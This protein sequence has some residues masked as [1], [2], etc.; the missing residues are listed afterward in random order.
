MCNVILALQGWRQTDLW[1][2]GQHSPLGKSQA[3]ERPHLKEERKVGAW[4][5]AHWLRLSFTLLQRTHIWFQHPYHTVHT[6][7]NSS[8][9]GSV[10][11][12]GLCEHPRTYSIYLH[13][14]RHIHVKRKMVSAWGIS[15]ADVGLSHACTHM[16][17][18][19]TLSATVS[20]LPNPLLWKYETSTQKEGRLSLVLVWEPMVVGLITLSLYADR[21]SWLGEHEDSRSSLGGQEAKREGEGPSP[22]ICSKSLLLVNSPPQMGSIT[23][24]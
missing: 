24:P 7:R 4:E 11:Y 18:D 15:E 23:S 6:H 10:P 21:T 2:T 5:R 12:Y 8:C 22:K 1:F 3:S 14:L 13:R 9:K 17:G 19:T 16:C 20:P